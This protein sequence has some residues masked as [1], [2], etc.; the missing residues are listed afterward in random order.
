LSAFP[1]RAVQVPND[2]SQPFADLDEIA[3]LCREVRRLPQHDTGATGTEHRHIEP[4]LR[5]LS[6][7][8]RP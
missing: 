7:R 8:I 2:L 4:L 5:P 1:N 6:Q 3:G